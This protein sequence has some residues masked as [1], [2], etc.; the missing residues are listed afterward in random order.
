MENKKSLKLGS[1]M[2]S[3]AWLFCLSKA[4]YKL[5]NKAKDLPVISNPVSLFDNFSNKSED[6]F[7]VSSPFP[8]EYNFKTQDLYNKW[9]GLIM[10]PKNSPEL[11]LE[12]NH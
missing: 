12:C 11:L 10:L 8:C 9:S 2:L 5:L 7:F 4:S 6:N 1:T 3:S